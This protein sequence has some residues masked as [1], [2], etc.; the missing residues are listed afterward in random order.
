MQ[1]S[2]HY[3]EYRE[4]KGIKGENKGVGNSTC[5]QDDSI[6]YFLSELKKEARHSSKL[7]KKNGEHV[8]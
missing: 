5:T 6:Q 3:G 2:L 8:R 7:R 1:H 4:N